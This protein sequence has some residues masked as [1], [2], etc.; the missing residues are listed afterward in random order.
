[1][2]LNF[3]TARTRFCIKTPT[4]SNHRSFGLKI[5]IPFPFIVSS[6]VVVISCHF[7]PLFDRVT[8]S[9]TRQVITMH[10]TNKIDAKKCN[11]FH[12]T[13]PSSSTCGGVWGERWVGGDALICSWK[14][15]DSWLCP[16]VHR[17]ISKFRV[18]RV[19][20]R[21]FHSFIWK[22]RV[23]QAFLTPYHPCRIYYP[24]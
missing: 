14:S 9:W 17:T 2:L 1:M 4:Y 18:H 7:P 10:T 13:P 16:R 11:K 24:L 23:Y 19:F 8:G 5:V 20:Y 22:R 12:R 6:V 21:L 15:V 3:G